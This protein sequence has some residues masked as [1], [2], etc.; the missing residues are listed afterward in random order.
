M[1]RERHGRGH[2]ADWAR[3]AAGAEVTSGPNVV[4]PSPKGRGKSGGGTRQI[5]GGKG[6]PEHRVN[7]GGAK[8]AAGDGV[9]SSV[10]SSGG[11]R[12]VLVAL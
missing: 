4:Q 6:S 11:R 8:A 12:G 9:P 5:Q 2:H 3:T 10:G 1:P 7:R